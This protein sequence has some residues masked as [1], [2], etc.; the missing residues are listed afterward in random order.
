M[1][2]TDAQVEKIPQVGI[3]R[4][5]T[6]KAATSSVVAAVPAKGGGDGMRRVQSV[7]QVLHDVYRHDRMIDLFLWLI[8]GWPL[9][10]PGSP[11]FDG[12]GG[13]A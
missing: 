13:D 7:G 9:N 5:A 4:S 3:E 8:E 6:V 10:G 11:A 12:R 1:G 2:T